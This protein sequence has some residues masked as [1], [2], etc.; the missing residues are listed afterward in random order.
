MK[1]VYVEDHSGVYALQ[2]YLDETH[3]YIRMSDKVSG[4]LVYYYYKSAKEEKHCGRMMRSDYAKK[5]IDKTAK[6]LVRL[7]NM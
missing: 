1:N 4:E 2:G 7:Y 3:G 6:S 5:L